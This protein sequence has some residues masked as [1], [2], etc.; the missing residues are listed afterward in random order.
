MEQA[1]IA[2]GLAE[3]ASTRRIMQF[4]EEV[5]KFFD[6]ANNALARS[7]KA[8]SGFG[9]AC[10]ITQLD[11]DWSNGETITWDTAY[12]RKAPNMCKVTMGFA[13]IH[14]LPL[15]LDADGGIANPAYPT[16]NIIQQI[17]GTDPWT[18][19]A[20]AQGYV[21]AMTAWRD[22]ETTRQAEQTAAEEEAAVAA[23]DVE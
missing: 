8:G 12:G 4:A 20:E 18:S 16:G 22:Q 11:F 6:P 7:F 10:A 17:F 19:G 21:D 13:P 3:P 9:L 23:G 15:G 5:V 14:D 2:A 1:A